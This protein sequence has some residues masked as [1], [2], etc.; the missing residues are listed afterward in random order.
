[1]TEQPNKHM[2]E[3]LQRFF[4][5]QDTVNLAYLF[6]SRAEENAGPSSDYDFGVL[7]DKTASSENRY[8]ITSE[9][10]QLLHAKKVDVVLL[11]NAPISLAHKIIASGNL[12]Y[13]RD[14]QTRVDCEARIMNKYGDYLPILRRQ[15]EDILKECMR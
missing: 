2:E 10:K 12:I 11:N 13:E 9:L 15:R 14:T 8:R 6:G 1:M 3:Q 7:L 4:A 5:S